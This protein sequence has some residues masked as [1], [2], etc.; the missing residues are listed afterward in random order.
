M[1]RIIKFFYERIRRKDTILLTRYIKCSKGCFHVKDVITCLS[2][3]V[4]TYFFRIVIKHWTKEIISANPWY[5]CNVIIIA[6]KK[7]MYDFLRDL[8][9]KIKLFT[10]IRKSKKKKII[11][12]SCY[13]NKTRSWNIYYETFQ[14]TRLLFKTSNNFFF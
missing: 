13:K 1:K 2:S 3:L 7:K 10:C 14:D 5:I 11:S 12:L 6:R 8:K 4:S 9:K